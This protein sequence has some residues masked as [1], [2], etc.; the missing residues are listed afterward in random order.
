VSGGS[1]RGR[2]GRPRSEPGQRC[3][4]RRV[5]RRGQRSRWAPRTLGRNSQRPRSRARIPRT[6]CQR[7]I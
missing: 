4:H 3:L 5:L 7:R 6:R 1:R 2:P